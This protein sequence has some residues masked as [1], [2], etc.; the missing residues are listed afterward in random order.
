M[1]QIKTYDPA[2]QPALESCFKA[3][4]ESLGWEYQ[5][6]GRHSDIVNI[7]E[8][9]MRHGECFWC[10]FQGD[11]LVGMAAV[12]CIDSDNRIAELK[13]LYVLPEYQGNGY[14]GMFFKY[15]LDYVKEQGYRIVRADTRHDRTASLRLIEKH[16]FRQIEQYNDNEFAELYFELDLT[17]NESEESPCP[18]ITTFSR[19]IMT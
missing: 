11:A 8:A 2:M 3:C 14:G 12:R 1:P 7:E 19:R 13:R 4:V 6:D 17:K 15:A 5:P 18:Q 16:R 10:L 9:Y